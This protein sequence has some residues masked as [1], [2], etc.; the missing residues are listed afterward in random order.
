MSESV[1][2]LL[3]A[4]KNGDNNSLSF[5]VDSLIFSAAATIAFSSTA[6]AFS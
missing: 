4:S 1:P 3:T 2:R 6:I 5:S